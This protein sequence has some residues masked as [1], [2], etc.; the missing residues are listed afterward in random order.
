MYEGKVIEFELTN[1]LTNSYANLIKTIQFQMLQVL[2]EPQ[3]ILEM[4]TIK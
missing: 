3:N 2:Q 1:K 4:K